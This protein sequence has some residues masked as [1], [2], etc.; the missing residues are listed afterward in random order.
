MTGHVP[1][2]LHTP[3]ACPHWHL[4]HFT[5]GSAEAHTHTGLFGTQVFNAVFVTKLARDFNFIFGNVRG[6]YGKRETA[7]NF[8]SAIG[9]HPSQSA[10]RLKPKPFSISAQLRILPSIGPYRHSVQKTALMI[11]ILS[12]IGF[13]NLIQTADIWSLCPSQYVYR[14]KVLFMKLYF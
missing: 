5:D 4:P 1:H 6:I 13:W 3:C 10:Q 7:K 11:S 9:S 8:C 12:F 2:A 14:S